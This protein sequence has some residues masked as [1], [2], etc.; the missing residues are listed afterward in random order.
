M[1]NERN[2][3][4]SFNDDQ[5]DGQDL[6]QQTAAKIAETKKKKTDEALELTAS[7]YTEPTTHGFPLFPKRGLLYLLP[8]KL[9]TAQQV[10]EQFPSFPLTMQEQL[11]KGEFAFVTMKDANGNRIIRP[12]LSRLESG[13]TVALLEE[14][15]S[16]SRT[17]QEDLN[18]R[19]AALE[20]NKQ[21]RKENEK[22]ERWNEKHDD[23]EQRPLQKEV[24]VPLVRVG[25][26]ADGLK[27]AVR[28]DKDGNVIEE[29]EVL[30]FIF[31]KYHVSPVETFYDEHWNVYV[32]TKVKIKVEEEVKEI[33]AFIHEHDTFICYDNGT[34]DDVEQFFCYNI[35]DRTECVTITKHTPDKFIF[36]NMSEFWKK[37][38]KHNL[39]G[40]EYTKYFEAIRSLGTKRVPMFEE[41]GRLGISQ[42]FTTHTNFAK[43]GSDFYALLVMNTP[44]VFDG[45][46]TGDDFLKL[47]EFFEDTLADASDVEI[48]FWLDLMDMK[49][50]KKCERVF[51]CQELFERY[52]TA[53]DVTANAHF[54]AFWEKFKK[55]A[56]HLLDDGT[57]SYISKER[58]TLTQAAKAK[59]TDKVAFGLNLDMMKRQAPKLNAAK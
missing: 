4:P 32:Q 6:K 51:T 33:P 52:G 29:E 22:A 41:S 14:F 40:C 57:L 24:P 27:Y 1:K 50:T 5:K 56:L 3:K 44:D 9:D 2:M 47:R 26:H 59:R 20:K 31:A 30:Q 8:T 35:K 10:A 18:A 38:F 54:G 39:N 43:F 48:R 42:F 7:P 45:I 13:L 36:L 15:I 58:K 19:K 17:F 25:Q 34:K 21:I 16:Q 55:A 23:D 46:E 49:K 37:Y 28:K 11:R 53:A 12:T